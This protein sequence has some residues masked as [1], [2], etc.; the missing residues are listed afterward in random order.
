M[1][2]F[3]FSHD[4]Y[5]FD[6]ASFH[7]KWARVFS[8]VNAILL[9]AQGSL[10]AMLYIGAD[11]LSQNNITDILTWTVAIMSIALPF[12]FLLAFFYFATVALSGFPYLSALA[13]ARVRKI[14]LVF[15]VWTVGRFV[16]GALLMLSLRF[17]WEASL[18]EAYL[19]A[20]IVAVLVVVE[21]IPFYLSLDWSTVAILITDMNDERRQ[22]LLNAPHGIMFS[23]DASAH[24]AHQRRDPEVRRLF[25]DP[26]SVLPVSDAD[27]GE[28]DLDDG[29]HLTISTDSASSSS[30]VVFRARHTASDG[31]AVDVVVRKFQLHELGSASM[32]DEY[33]QDLALWSNVDHPHVARFVGVYRI[34]LSVYSCT[35]AHG[36]PL[37][38]LI[39][40]APKQPMA[41][42]A[43]IR[44]A[45][46]M[47]RALSFLQLRR[48]TQG[49]GGGSG[50]SSI[51]V[52]HGQL[53]SSSVMVWAAC[54]FP[55]PR[56]CLAFAIFVGDL[57]SISVRICLSL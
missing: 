37:D 32:C 31:A 16:R 22:Q 15:V 53:S 20:L 51:G 34:G 49:A 27:E 18:P 9:V 52:G 42:P 26:N 24:D 8:I 46:Q 33:A 40:R 21:I 47:C 38:R 44:L 48:R 43:L 56:T 12:C 25:L 4:Q 11:A 3:I 54:S 19:A 1:E 39:A 45:K 30:S 10:Y 6:F 36:V 5:H 13:H 23:P 57:I 35:E 17:D 50:G 41:A 7:R 55:P 28:G 29:R 2:I 14:N